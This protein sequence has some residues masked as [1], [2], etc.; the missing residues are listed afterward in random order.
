MAAAPCGAQPSARRRAPAI[1]G[2]SVT[3]RDII[4]LLS[5]VKMQGVSGLDLVPRVKALRPWVP[6]VIVSAYGDAERGAANLEGRRRD[7]TAVFTDITGFTAL[8]E[9]IEP[10]ALA[11]PLN[12]C[13]GGTTE[14]IFAHG[15][16]VSKV[17]GDGMHLL[18]GAPADQPDHPARGVA[19]APDAFAQAYRA[20]CRAAGIGLGPTRIGLHAAPALIGD[21]GGGRYFD[22]GAYGD[23]I[24]TAA[25]LEVANKARGTRICAS[26]AMPERVPGFAGRRI[27]DLL[28]RGRG[29]PLAAHEA[30]TPAWAESLAA[31]VAAF[32]LP[33][34]RDPPAVGALA[35]YVGRDADDRLS[36]FHRRG[37]L[38]GESGAVV[39]I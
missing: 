1:E 33:E 34:R 35:A 39:E 13:L 10:A 6:V 23:T 24:A 26:P 25:R 22:F 17:M 37:L 11:G 16:T 12:G 7:V 32:D 31:Y 36:G 30:L 4:L 2:G 3:I 29:A 9:T 18:F 14:I 19:C 21:F 15:G 28:L 5:A 8:V 27:G 20:R 38:T